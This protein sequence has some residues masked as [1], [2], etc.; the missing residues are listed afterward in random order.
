MCVLWVIILYGVMYKYMQ[1]CA[2]NT[3]SFS[4]PLFIFTFSTSITCF[5]WFVLGIVL[6]QYKLLYYYFTKLIEKRLDMTVIQIVLNIC[7]T[8]KWLYRWLWKYYTRTVCYSRD[9]LRVGT[10]LFCI[11]RLFIIINGI[12]RAQ[13]S[14]GAANAPS[15]LLHGNSYPRTGTFSVVSWTLAVKCPADGVRLED[16][17]TRLVRK[18]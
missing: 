12:Y 3:R 6:G 14:Q 4:E 16:C 17:S 10:S 5:L 9:Q 13:T 18:R 7:L 2:M 15:L 1:L 8:C 11:Y